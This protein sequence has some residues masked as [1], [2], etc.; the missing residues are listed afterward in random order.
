MPTSL[1]DYSMLHS[2]SGYAEPQ[3]TVDVRVNH[4]A[5]NKPKHKYMGAATAFE[6]ELTASNIPEGEGW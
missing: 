2:L 4:S 3:K 1:C 6:R 5:E